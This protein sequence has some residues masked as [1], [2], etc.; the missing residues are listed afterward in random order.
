MKEIPVMPKYTSDNAD[1]FYAPLFTIF[2]VERGICCFVSLREP[3]QNNR[4]TRIAH[5][6]GTRTRDSDQSCIDKRRLQLFPLTE[7]T[8]YIHATH[9]IPYQVKF[10]KADILYTAYA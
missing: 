3:Q 4:T 8:Q 9:G 1:A 6:G 2:S 5:L 7:E 10:P